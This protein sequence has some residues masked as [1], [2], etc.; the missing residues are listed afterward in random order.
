[1][2]RERRQQV[3]PPP[4][5]GVSRRAAVRMEFGGQST[6]GVS[7]GNRRMNPMFAPA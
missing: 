4:P 3:Q 5:D 1:M 2:R 7:G 6:E